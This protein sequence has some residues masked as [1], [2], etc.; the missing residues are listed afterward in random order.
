VTTALKKLLYTASR[1][2]MADPVP[3]VPLIAVVMIETF[4]ASGISFGFA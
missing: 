3:P 2:A 1:R 4:S